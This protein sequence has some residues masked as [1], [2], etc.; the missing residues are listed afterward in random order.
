MKE[1]E[2]K[3]AFR[4]KPLSYFPFSKNDKVSLNNRISDSD[5]K[6]ELKKRPVDKVQMRELYHTTE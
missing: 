1:F 3:M 5:I 4:E 2:E 6:D